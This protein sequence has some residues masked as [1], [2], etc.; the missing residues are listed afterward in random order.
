MRLMRLMGGD[1]GEE[2][3]MEA[4]MEGMMEGDDGGWDDGRRG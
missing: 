2:K 3:M 1:G 4:M